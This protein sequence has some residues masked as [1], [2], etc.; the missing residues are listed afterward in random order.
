M[1]QLAFLVAV[2]V[3]VFAMAMRQAPLWA[4]AAF[5]GIAT[6]ALRTGLACGALAMRGMPS[7]K[8]EAAVVRRVHRTTERGVSSPTRTPE[9]WRVFDGGVARRAAVASMAPRASRRVIGLFMARVSLA[10]PAHPDS[11][12]SRRHDVGLPPVD[13]YD[14]IDFSPPGE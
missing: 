9:A 10:L 8:R 12:E 1:L 7:A 11:Q 13:G 6:F 4:W 5:A 3:I 2:V 14:D